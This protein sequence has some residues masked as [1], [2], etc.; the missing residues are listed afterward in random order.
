MSPER[1]QGTV[2]SEEDAMHSEKETMHLETQAGAI[3]SVQ[4]SAVPLLDDIWSD[5]DLEVLTAVAEA[6]Q[7]GLDA[8]SAG[9]KAGGQALGW[10]ADLAGDT[11]DLADG[12]LDLLGDAFIHES[13]RERGHWRLGGDA[14]GGSS[15][16]LWQAGALSRDEEGLLS[17]SD[18]DL[19]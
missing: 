14:T 10:E 3:H 1:V 4:A 6:G 16:D 17:D 9:M 15:T 19:R 12:A 18:D 8:S 7:P 5:D 11:L 2:P 13:D